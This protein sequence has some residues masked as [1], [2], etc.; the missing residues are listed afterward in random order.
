MN[1]D[2]NAPGWDAIDGALQ[3][4][5]RGTKPLHWAPVV[6]AVAVGTDPLS[7]VSAWRSSFGGREH[8]HYVSYGFTDLFAKESE[9]PEVSGYGFELTM[10]VVDP[11]GGDAAPTW[12]VSVMQNLARYVFASGNPFGAGHHLPFNGPIALG[13]KTDLVAGAIVTDPQLTAGGQSTFGKFEFLQ[14]VGLTQAEYDA[15]YRWDTLRFLAAATRHD[16][17]LLT[18]LPRESWLKNPDFREVVA[19]GTAR[20]GSSMTSLFMSKGSLDPAPLPTWGIA[21]NSLGGVETIVRGRLGFERDALVSWGS[22]ALCLH[23]GTETGFA[24]DGDLPTLTLSKADQEFLC[25]LPQKRGDY[26]AP[27]G[28]LVVRV[29]PVDIL[30]GARK[31]VVRTIG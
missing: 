4:L 3:V 22:R 31:K 2:T 13:R 10:R 18:D 21:A 9:V 7:G 23:A 8:W 30:D 24:D 29:L 11:E 27:S 19:Q 5:Y 16:P 6:P 28:K 12:P 14:L 26:P 25:A 1:D 17:A 20:D 15:V